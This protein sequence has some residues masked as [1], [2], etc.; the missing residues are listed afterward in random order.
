VYIVF[1][2]PF[3]DIETNPSI[4]EHRAIVDA[5]RL[6]DEEKAVALMREHLALSMQELRRPE[7]EVV[8]KQEKE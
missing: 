3:Y 6:R 5:L 1:Y 8:Q 4:A 7:E 2:D